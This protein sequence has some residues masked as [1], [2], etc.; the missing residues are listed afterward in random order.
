LL[1]RYADGSPE[2][3]MDVLVPVVVK[4]MAMAMMFWRTCMKWHYSPDLQ[5]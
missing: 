3:R 2:F 5:A 1:I 4:H